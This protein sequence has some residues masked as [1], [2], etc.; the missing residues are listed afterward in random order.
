MYKKVNLLGIQID[1]LSYQEALVSV[2]QC[3]L[4]GEP[5]YISWINLNQIILYYQNER[6]RS[7]VDR[8]RLILT[9]GQP[10]MWIAR[11][12]KTPL[13]EKIGGTDFMLSLCSMFAEKG[14]SIFLL[15]GA[16]G[17]ETA[18]ADNL[19]Q[20]YPGLK[21]AGAYSPPFGFEKDQIELTK[22]NDMLRMS[23]ADILF[24]GLGSPKQD[25]FIEE[26]IDNYK[27]P[28]TF[29]TGSAIDI[30]GG[31]V[32]RAPKWMTRIGL[33]WFYRFCQEP[34]RLFR[35]YFIDSWK[36]IKYIYIF[37]R[38]NRNKQDGDFTE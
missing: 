31:R 35:R 4:H 9:D 6:F 10:V 24:V 34:Q 36:I 11:W 3:I 28:I 5:C 16:P 38:E 8:A 37:R 19:R 20:R 32:K 33:E 2:E 30:I 15:G 14:Y 27:I 13:Q 18:A 7:I 22:I 26:N 29:P 1:N 21:I 17:M 23:H 25:Y 12:L